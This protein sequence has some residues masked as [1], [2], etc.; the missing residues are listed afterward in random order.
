MSKE[1]S[2]SRSIRFPAKLYHQLEAFASANQLSFTQA[3]IMLLNSAVQDPKLI[4]PDD[5]HS[6]DKTI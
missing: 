4:K 6:I 5:K 1:K 2:K 3:V